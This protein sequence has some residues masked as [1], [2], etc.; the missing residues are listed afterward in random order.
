MLMLGILPGLA[1]GRIAIRPRDALPSLPVRMITSAFFK[2]L[3]TLTWID[4]WVTEAGQNCCAGR[5]Q[6]ALHHCLSLHEDPQDPADPVDY[7]HARVGRADVE[8]RD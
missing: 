7:S 3:I 4:R 2:P 6:T 1:T 8:G 5:S